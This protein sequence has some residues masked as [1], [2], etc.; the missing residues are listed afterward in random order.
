M[1]KVKF[2][3]NDGNY[4]VHSKMSIKQGIVHRTK[5]KWKTI[6]CFSLIVNIF[7]IGYVFFNN[8]KI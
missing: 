3:Q 5:T 4:P 2:K 1:A 7:L 6:A 8:Y